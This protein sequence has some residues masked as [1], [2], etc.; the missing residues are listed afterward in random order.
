MISYNES[1]LEKVTFKKRYKRFLADVEHPT[2]GLLT[3]HCANSGSLKSCLEPDADAWILDSKDPKRKLRYTLELIS[4]TDGLACINTQRANTLIGELFASIIPGSKNAVLSFLNQQEFLKDFISI[5]DKKA[6]AVF[7]Q[8]TRFDFLINQKSKRSW[9]EVKSVSLR[10]DTTTIAF[11]DAVT[12]RGQK[13]IAHLLEC[14]AQ[15]DD[16]FLFFVI[17]RSGHLSP[18]VASSQFRAA[19]E[20]DPTYA[21]ALKEAHKQGLKI[22]LL[23]TSISPQGINV[24]GY[25]P[26]E[27]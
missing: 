10:L 2:L 12:E 8:G 18:Q 9:V 26:W 20:I 21:R 6:E 5:E 14:Q 19:H 16:A 1:P 17:M 23:T 13:H 4:C 25:F 27:P 24:T 15:G 22:R 7:K 11:P 3:A